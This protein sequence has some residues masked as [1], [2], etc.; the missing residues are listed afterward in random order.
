MDNLDILE[1]E[2]ERKVILVTGGV[3]FIGSHLCKKLLEDSKNVVYCLD[4]LITGKM[5]NIKSLV[6]NKRFHFILQNVVHLLDDEKVKS[7][8]KID[9]IYHLACIASP[10]KYM[11][12]SIE[13]LDTCFIGTRNILE[14]AKKHNSKV[15]FSS[16]SEVYGDPLVNPQPETYYGNVN[17]VGCRSCYDEGK[18]VAETLIYEY[19]KKY[20]INAKIIRIFNTYGPNMDINDGRVITNFIKQIMRKEVLKIYGNGLQTRSFCY[21]SDLIEGILSMMKSDENGPI[22]LGNPYCEFTLLELVKKMEEI[23]N[24]ELNVLFLN[25]TENDPQ[26]RRPDITLAREKLCFEPMIDLK[27]GLIKTMEYFMSNN[28]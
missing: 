9:E 16:T 10:D 8:E 22:N 15:L 14:L 24:Q 20:G 2:K 4:N 12:Y 27:E 19:R 17:T 6:S 13:T 7:I 11:V 3:G 26:Q 1:L 18:R 21:I 28:V 25:S 5:I 23:T